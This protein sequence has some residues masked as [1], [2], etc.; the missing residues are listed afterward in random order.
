MSVYFNSLKTCCYYFLNV[1][2]N[3]A[4]F[5]SRTVFDFPVGTVVRTLCFYC[6]VHEFNFGQETKILYA[7]LCDQKKK[8]LKS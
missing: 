8:R 2:S 4:E 5:K 1:W 3:D 6:R 7:S